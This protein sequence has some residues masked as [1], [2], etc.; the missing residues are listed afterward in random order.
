MNNQKDIFKKRNCKYIYVEYWDKKFAGRVK[1]ILLYFDKQFIITKKIK[2]KKRNKMKMFTRKLWK[3]FHRVTFYYLSVLF[4]FNHNRRSREKC[5]LRVHYFAY[6]LREIQLTTF[7]RLYL[8]EKKKKRKE[9]KQTKNRNYIIPWE[10]KLSSTQCIIR[11][12]QWR[13]FI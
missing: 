5:K 2:T 6:P 1:K 9:R 3:L 10:L 12:F 4:Y 13:W 7:R 11:S 8:V